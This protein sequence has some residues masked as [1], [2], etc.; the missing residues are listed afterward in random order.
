MR[1][2]ASSRRS[3]RAL[4]SCAALLACAALPTRLSAQLADSKVLTA[5]AV[6]A[7]LAAAEAK[8]KAN[9]WVVSIAV[10]DAGGDLLGFVRLD[11][12][13]AGTAQV[14][15]G[16]ARTAARWQRPSKVYADR[17]MA[18]T[19]TFL[20]VDGLYAL[21]GGLPITI[22]GR[23]IGAVGVSGVSSAQDEEIAAAG[24]AAIKP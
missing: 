2:S 20:S 8:A 13:S 5:D 16:K 14:A 7:V 18:D 9:R 24:I 11:G 4:L 19:L 1:L 23:V 22:N 6:K 17:I 3:V 21:Q 15:T 12:A 10:V